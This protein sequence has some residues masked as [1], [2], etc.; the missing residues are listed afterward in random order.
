MTKFP[1]H[2]HLFQ[3][4][5]HKTEFLE[6]LIEISKLK[7]LCTASKVELC[8]LTND[9][10]KLISYGNIYHKLI[11]YCKKFTCD[12]RLDKIGTLTSVK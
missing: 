9:K 5:G 12:H 4:G 7:T 10:T 3:N 8:S 6:H 1:F 11:I 2:N